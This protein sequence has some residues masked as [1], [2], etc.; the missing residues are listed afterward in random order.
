MC[1][2]EKAHQQF[3][4]LSFSAQS[5]AARIADMVQVNGADADAQVRVCDVLE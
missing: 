5:D 3:A 1:R 4:L 2:V